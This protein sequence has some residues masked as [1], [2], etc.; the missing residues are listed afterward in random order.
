MTDASITNIQIVYP[1]TDTRQL[2]ITVG[3][4]RL[5]IAPGDGPDW[6]TGTYRDPTG[7]IPCRIATEGGN[8]RISQDHRWRGLLKE[9]PVFDLKVGKTE[10]FDITIES[11]ASDETACDFGGL[12]VTALDVKHGAGKF[13]LDF[14][15]PNPTEMTRLRVA[16]GAAEMVVTNLANANAAEI[17]IEGGAAAFTFDFG[18]TL[19]RDT[20]VKINTGM[21]SLEIRVP[22]TTAARITPHAVLGSVD[23]G[24]GFTTRGGAYWTAAAVAE[25]TPILAIDATIAL[26]SLKI[27]ST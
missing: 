4:A 18:G 11:G 26:G 22:A 17:S 14:A 3:P 1:E 9:T 13:N 6:V 23:P 10:P 15:A 21:A 25:A 20:R 8:A 16:A 12:P 7:K 19:Q 27:R 5:R 24:D 2:R